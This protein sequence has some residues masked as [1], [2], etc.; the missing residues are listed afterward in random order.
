MLS[1][2]DVDGIY[3]APIVVYGVLALPITLV[4][5][6]ILFRLG[7]LRLVWH[8]ALFIFA[9]YVGILSLLVLLV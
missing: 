3:V 4:L 8:P 1:E 9:V 5:R 2:V 7:A 6:A